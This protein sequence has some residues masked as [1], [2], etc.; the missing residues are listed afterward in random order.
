MLPNKSLSLEKYH[1]FGLPS[2]AKA[3]YIINSQAKLEEFISKSHDISPRIFLGRGTNTVFIDDVIHNVIII[4]T[5]GVKISNINQEAVLISANAGESWNALAWKCVN[6]GLWGMENLV[7]IPGSI[8][9]S[10]VQ[11]IGAFAQE[12]KNLVHRVEY[13]NLK[14][15]SKHILT[16][17]ECQFGYRHSIFKNL[18]DF[19][20]GEILITKIELILHKSPQPI[21]TYPELF[22]NIP[23]GKPID[24][25]NVLEIAE[26]VRDIRKRKMP[27][28]TNFGNAGSFYKNVNV[29]NIELN[30]L[31]KQY[32]RIPY[33]PTE[34]A[35]V[36]KIPTA[37]LIEN[38][39]LKGY[40]IGNIGVSH[41]HALIVGF[42]KHKNNSFTR[43]QT[44][45]NFYNL[46]SF[47]NTKIWEKYK[48]KIDPEVLIYPTVMSAE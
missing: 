18:D 3:I 39:G 14:T 2:K 41:Q 29:N 13:I 21:I 34:T 19:K 42:I 31:L 27:K 9:A 17:A 4:R 15:K 46:I 22:K 48:L 44:S 37:W 33:F 28:T 30:N 35:E 43:K 47:I 7:E 26:T 12:V 8:G 6:L 20:N 45:E 1:S 10:V 38:A 40:Q 36:F 16:N 24:R 32:P 25:L 11:N 5:K 23:H